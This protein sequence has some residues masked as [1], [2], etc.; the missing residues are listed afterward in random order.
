MGF[1]HRIASQN[2]STA[3]MPFTGVDARPGRAV[4]AD[5]VGSTT[6]KG[7]EGDEFW[8]LDSMELRR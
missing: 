1:P 2:T 3:D 4:A 5:G 8:V 7:K 6:K